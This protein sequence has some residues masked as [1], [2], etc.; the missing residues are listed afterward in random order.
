MAVLV[1]NQ[2]PR[3]VCKRQQTRYLLLLLQ[4]NYLFARSLVVVHKP[5]DGLL[6]S[7]GHCCKFVVGE[8]LS[9]LVVAGSLFVLA[10]ALAGIE[11][12][13]A[14]ELHCL[15]YGQGNV[16]D[17]HFVGLVDTQNDGIGFV[18]FSGDPY[19]ELREISVVDKLSERCSA[20][21]DRERSVVLFGLVAFVDQTGNHVALLYRKVVVFSVDV[22]GDD[23]GKVASV[24]FR[25][26][27]IHGVDH[28]FCVSV[29]LVGVMGWSVVNHGLVDG[30]GRLVRE[31]TRAQHAD[32]LLDLVDPRAFHDVVVHEHVEAIKFDLFG[33]VG[34]ETADFCRQMND[35]SR[36]V[37]LENSF[38]RLS[39]GEITILAGQKDP[40]LSGLF[41]VVFRY[42]IFDALAHQSGT[43]GDHHHGR[44]R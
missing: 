14:L 15:C 3:R 8:V 11:F 13:L 26:G 27:T 2:N 43:A 21:P 42:E 31:N 7:I 1:V 36:P 9:K 44:L 23:G 19:R 38:G 37:L 41:V 10:V 32:E 29:S 20:S 6:Y 18:V 5:I 17:G 35:M 33:H 30:I 28:A 12:D 34:K 4:R 24:F 25:I 40:G 39:I 16:L 22:C